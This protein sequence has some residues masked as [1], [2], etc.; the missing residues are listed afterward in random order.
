VFPLGIIGPDL[1]WWVMGLVLLALAVLVALYRPAIRDWLRQRQSR[2]WQ[3]EERKAQDWGVIFPYYVEVKSLRELAQRV[4]L[5]LPSSRRVTTS[6]RLNLGIK[7]LGGQAGGS[8]TEEFE[9]QIPLQELAFEA[10]RSW[11]SGGTGPAIAVATAPYL[12]S[13]T[14]VSTAIEQVEEEGI[15]NGA[16]ELLPRIQELFREQR[17]EALVNQKKFEFHSIAAR[18][19]LMVFQGQ[20][21]FLQEGEEGCGPTLQ[22]THFNPSFGFPVP[23]AAK[24]EHEKPGLVP[25]PKEVGLNIALPDRESLLPA[26]RERILRR[27]PFYAGVIA[28]SPSFNLETGTL[29]CSAWA[30]WGAA[31]PTWDDLEPGYPMMRTFG[32][33]SPYHA[34]PEV[35]QGR[36]YKQGQGPS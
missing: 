18:N 2:R 25:V 17:E 7:G 32:S 23:P 29:T 26:G 14:M 15:P 8:E 31:T 9:G 30:V 19:L 33:R 10:E 1:L 22:L 34:G 16:P 35:S 28:H 6:R 24:G 36:R 13:R 5:E 3:A 11:S 4:N 27:S 12:D 20:C 21:A